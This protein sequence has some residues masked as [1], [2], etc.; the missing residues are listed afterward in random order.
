MDEKHPFARNGTFAFST[1]HA[2]YQLTDG[3]YLTYRERSG[4]DMTYRERSGSDMKPIHRGVDLVDEMLKKFEGQEPTVSLSADYLHAIAEEIGNGEHVSLYVEDRTKPVLVL[5]HRME[6][7]GP[8]H[9]KRV[10][11]LMPVYS[12]AIY[13]LEK[14]QQEE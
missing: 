11:V 14:K 3:C 7:E 8:H 10:A 9:P 1:E 13:K 6:Y 2:T 5:P 12:H 4:S